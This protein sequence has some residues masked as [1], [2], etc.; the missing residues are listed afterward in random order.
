MPNERVLG[1]SV[2]LE[3]LDDTLFAQR[4]VLGEQA[5]P[6]P[7]QEYLNDWAGPGW[8]RKFYGRDSDKPQFDLTPATE[9]AVAWLAGLTE[10]S[11]VGTESGLLLF[12]E[13]LRQMDEGSEHDS[14]RRLVQ[15]QKPG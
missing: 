2:L 5:F 9:K 6:K 15:L 1:Q 4:S 14:Q 13:L 11:F 8:L 7:A 10:R 12:F 3:K